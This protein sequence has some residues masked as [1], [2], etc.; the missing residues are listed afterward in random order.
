VILVS[1]RDVGGW[2]GGFGEDCST[3]SAV[4]GGGVIWTTAGSTI[5]LSHPPLPILNKLWINVAYWYI[6]RFLF[7][8]CFCCPGAL[9][10]ALA[11]C[12]CC[13]V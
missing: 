4:G 3:S 9:L 12:G 8:C 2:G 13:T 10:F 5:L 1:G 11:V 7:D 6:E